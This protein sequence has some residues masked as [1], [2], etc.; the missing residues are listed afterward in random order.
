MNKSEVVGEVAARTG[1]NRKEAAGAVEAVFEA[2]TEALARREEG[3]PSSASSPPAPGPL[4]QRAICA[5]A[6]PWQSRL[7][8]RRRSSPPGRPARP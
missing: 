8:P 4:V 3:L 6:S 1:L 7:R 2:V 5:R